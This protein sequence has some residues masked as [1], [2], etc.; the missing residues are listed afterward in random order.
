MVTDAITIARGLVVAALGTT[1][2]VLE[3]AADRVGDALR[4]LHKDDCKPCFGCDAE[5]KGT[6]FRGL[7]QRLC[8][9]CWKEG[10]RVYGTTAYKRFKV[11]FGP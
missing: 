9:E 1:I 4:I 8:S 3:F 10:V 6:K 11:R 7:D 5:C 2:D